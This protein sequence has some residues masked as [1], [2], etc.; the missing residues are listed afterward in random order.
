MSVLDV[1]WT[2]R[3]PLV[4]LI[5]YDSNFFRCEESE[6]NLY[7][8]VKSISSLHSS[9]VVTFQRFYTMFKLDLADDTSGKQTA[10]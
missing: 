9:S 3:G 7:S 2:S 1:E 5:L 4:N 10:I 6:Q 8:V